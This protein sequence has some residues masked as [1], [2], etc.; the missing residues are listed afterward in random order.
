[1]VY[2]VKYL[3]MKEIRTI[4]FNLLQQTADSVANPFASR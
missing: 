3:K 2:Q 4:K 1:M